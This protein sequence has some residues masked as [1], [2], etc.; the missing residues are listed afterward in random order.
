[1]LLARWAANVMDVKGAFLNGKFSDG[2]RLYMKVPEGFEKHYGNNVVLLLLK[3]IYG[4]KQAAMCFWRELVR[5]M[6]EMGHKRSKADPCMYYSWNENEKLAI[7]LSW[8]DDN[9]CVG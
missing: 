3:T 6:T 5:V 8:I 9:L 7:W 4:L 1:M 2:E